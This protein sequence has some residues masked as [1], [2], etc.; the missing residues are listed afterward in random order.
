[1]TRFLIL[2]GVL[3]F[4]AAATE[5]RFSGEAIAYEVTA[6]ESIASLGARFGL[7]PRTLAADNGLSTGTVLEPGQRLVIDNR[8]VIADHPADGIL[9]NVP[10]RMLFVFVGDCL[11]GAY[12]VAV[13]RPGWRTPLGVFTVSSKE[14]DPT[15]DVPKSI[16]EE[17]SEAG[18]QVETRVLP[19]PNNPLGDRWIGV[20]NLGFGIHGTNQSSSIYRFT[21]HGCIRLHP[22]DARSLFEI[23]WIGMPI[24]IVYQPILLTAVDPDHIMVEVH[25]DVYRRTA[26]A[27]LEVARRLLELDAAIVDVPALNEII[28]RR[29]G[30]GSVLERVK[31]PLPLPT[32]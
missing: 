19:G 24:W 30:R 16:Q 29:A 13:G 15:W 10:Q 27:S 18:R 14:V 21:T 17:M 3:S 26:A 28:R 2:V 22:A 12:P 11:A 7:E 9:I 25:A 5:Q 23:A 31:Q 4:Q 1:V 20:S 8:H 6:G 32:W